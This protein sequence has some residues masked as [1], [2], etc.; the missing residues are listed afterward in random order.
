VEGAVS[1]CVWSADTV[2]WGVGVA[3]PQ[4]PHR[5]G[6]MDWVVLPSLASCYM[7]LVG[8]ADPE[9]TYLLVNSNGSCCRA[10]RTTLSTIV[11]L[12]STYASAPAPSQTWQ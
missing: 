8:L 9:I 11:E 3:S 7:K 10:T 1:E 6:S 4:L 12:G 2:S 5:S